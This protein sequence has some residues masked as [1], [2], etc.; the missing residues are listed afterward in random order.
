[1]RNSLFSHRH[2]DIRSHT[3]AL[4]PAEEGGVINQIKLS[5][6]ALRKTHRLTQSEGLALIQREKS[7][8]PDE[9]RRHR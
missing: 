8:F 3:E 4:K 1:M 6:H 9:L 5:A 2:A 7:S